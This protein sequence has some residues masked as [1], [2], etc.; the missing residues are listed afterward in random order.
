MNR[1]LFRLRLCAFLLNIFKEGYHIYGALVYPLY[2]H[3]YLGGW[4]AIKDIYSKFASAG[5]GYDAITDSVYI[6][7]YRFAFL[8]SVTRNYKPINYYTYATAAWG[9]GSINDQTFPFA[10]STN[11]SVSPMAC[12]YQRFSSSSD[13]GTAYFTIEI[14]SSNSS[15]MMLNK[16]TETSTGTLS[17]S[18]VSTSFTRIT[19]QQ[20]NFGLTI[21]KLTLIPVNTNSSGSAINYKLTAS[22]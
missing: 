12:R 15:G 19:V 1:L 22:N 10:S 18:T 6:S 9:T 13:I 4:A 5:N 20:A 17:I 11:M 16:I 14:T 21:K 2:I 8:A 7:D 3:T